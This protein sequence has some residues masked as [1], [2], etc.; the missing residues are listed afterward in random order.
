MKRYLA[1]FLALILCFALVGCNIGS[2]PIT[3]PAPATQPV[4]QNNQGASADSQTTQQQI[5]E[6][7]A[8]DIALNHAGLKEADVAYVNLELDYDDGVLRYEVDFQKDRIEYD[9]EID[10]Y[11]G[12][13]LSYDKDY[14][15]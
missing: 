5:T 13:I 12:N 8:K 11:T 14:D 1:L 10:A 15:D 7:Q 2:K 3:Q 6:Q 4:I 9:Y